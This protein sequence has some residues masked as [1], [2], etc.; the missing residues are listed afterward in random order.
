MAT[1]RSRITVPEDVLF[2]DLEGEAVVLNLTSG[3]YYGL[4]E[5]GTRM[6]AL[7]SEHGAVQPAYDALLAEYAVA[8]GQL[9]GDLLALVE[10]LEGHGLLRVAET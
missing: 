3:K 7:L 9:R 4:D 1:M 10:K 8:E 6:W 2:R 5:V